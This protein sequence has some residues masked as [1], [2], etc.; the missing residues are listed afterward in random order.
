[1]YIEDGSKTDYDDGYKWNRYSWGWL[2]DCVPQDKLGWK[3]QDLKQEVVSRLLEITSEQEEYTDCEGIIKKHDRYCVHHHCGFHCC[4]ICK[5]HDIGDMHLGWNGSI[6]IKYKWR[7]FRAPWAVVHYIK[8]HDY[9]PGP[10]VIDALF[11]GRIL[12]YNEVD[13]K[14]HDRMWKRWE[15]EREKERKEAE[16]IERQKSPEQ[17]ML[18]QQAKL[19]H[20]LGQEKLRQLRRD[21]ALTK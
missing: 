11:N 9:N 1:M 19:I 4:E 16:R 18:E 2:G 17:K 10:K 13:Q 5:N 20:K 6:L 15:K 3:D 21:G 14:I 7:E 8:K 12:T